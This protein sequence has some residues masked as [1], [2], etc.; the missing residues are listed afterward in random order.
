LLQRIAGGKSRTAQVARNV[1]NLNA[2][3]MRLHLDTDFAGDTD[4]ACAL[5]MLLGWE[6]VE[7]VGVTTVADP[8]GRRAGYVQ[9]FLELAGRAGIP[10][11]A[12]AG[13]SLT[14]GRPMG[15]LPDHATYWPAPVAARPSPPGAAV[16][17]LAAGI[18]QGATIAAIGPYTN[19]AEV[20]LQR[21]GLLQ[22]VPIVTMG[23]WIRPADE[24]LPAWGPDMDWNVQCDT[25]AATT[26]FA[27]S[28]DLTLVTLPATLK[29]S[30]RAAHLPRLRAAG[31]LGR[32][33]ARQAEAHATE[34]RMTELGRAHSGLPDDLLNFQYDPV[35]CAV[36]VG[37]TGAVAEDVR[38]RP[39][40]ERDVLHFQP[41]TGGKRVRAVFD[42]D[43]TAFAETWLAAVERA[44]VPPGLTI[45]AEEPVDRD[46]IGE[47]VAAAFGSPV[48]AR[49]VE[50]IRASSNFVPE[51][52]LVAELDGRVVGHVM[53]SY[54]ALHDGHRDHRIA[55]LSPLAVAPELHG[56]GIGTAL[57]RAVTARADALGEPLVVL[58]GS[59]VYY[60]R[61]GFEHSVPHGIEIAL[62]SWA[63]AEAAQVLRLGRY[64]P[65]L[66]GRVVYPPAFAEATEH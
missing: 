26:V 36:A 53:I 32:L 2:F 56:R 54:A 25:E 38:L 9:R 3:S 4:D 52:S 20:E 12:G 66:R 15:E 44:H 51:L 45:R 8:D 31:R 11:A 35:A 42:I 64:D 24:G 49:L 65:S 34:H 28:A 33:L 5:A 47:V 14:T 43:G 37:W 21:P 55:T 60:G 22:R 39:V 62:P 59:P 23:G 40:L 10:V 61:F 50:A 17:L 63:P 13:T 58:E 41:E 48:E 27:R 46:A 1:A 19:L 57:V 7:V 6:D 30:L 18:E 29:A 16:E